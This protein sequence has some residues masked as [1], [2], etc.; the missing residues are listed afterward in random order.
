[1]TSRITVA[2]GGSGKT[3]HLVTEALTLEEERIAL[4]TY[5]NSNAGVIRQMLVDLAGA[6]PPRIEVRTWFSFLLQECA[7]PYQRAVCPGRRIKTIHFSDTRSARYAPYANTA[8]YYFWDGDEIYSDKIARFVLDCERLTGGLVTHRLAAAY[9]AIFIDEFQDMAGYDLDVLEMLLRSGVYVVLAGD[10]RQA[11]YATNPAKKNSQYRGIAVLDKTARWVREGL[12]KIEVGA[13]SQRSN[14]AICDFADRL[15]PELP[16]TASCCA[17]ETGHDGVF[18]VAPE[19]LDAYMSAY[20]PL[21]LR[22]DKRTDAHGYPA[23]TF[24]DSKGLTVPR[25][26]ILPHGPIERYL[27]NGDVLE[28]EKS[29]YR[30][31]VGITRARFSVAFLYAGECWEEL[32]HWEAPSSPGA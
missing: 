17:Q 4:L 15:W 20:A 28:V 19:H 11:T 25:V 7:R 29:K 23:R 26:L 24:G 30:F 18:L 3:T 27:R 10:P 1:V 13:T 12:C 8:A 9:D 32:R 16:A 14:Q 2:P 31:Y 22:Y 6:I 5:T 21:V